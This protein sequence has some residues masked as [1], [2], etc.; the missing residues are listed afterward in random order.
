MSEKNNE[1]LKLW[2]R[3]GVS[4]NMTPDEVSILCGDDYRK[5]TE[6]LVSV[7]HSDRCMLDG[8]TYFPEIVNI[9]EESKVPDVPW[10][11]DLYKPLHQQPDKEKEQLSVHSLN[12]PMEIK[13]VGELRAALANVPDSALLN[14]GTKKL[15]FDVTRIGYDGIS[16]ALESSDLEQEIANPLVPMPGLDKLD[17]TGF[18]VDTPHGTLHVYDKKDNEYPGVWVDLVQEDGRDVTLAMVE[19]ISGGEGLSDFDPRHPEVMRRQREEVPECRRSGDE[20]TAGFVTRSWPDDNHDEEGH[21]RTFHYGYPIPR[22]QTLEE[23]VT[24]AQ[25][26]TARPEPQKPDQ[27]QGRGM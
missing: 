11:F 3:V 21:N 15:G 8:E 13:T 14:I 26:R 9:E 25:E 20:V 17:E 2:A 1:M 27:E 19:Y 5:A 6:M 10:E 22:Q 16:V 12:I 23:K 24:D 18:T 7:L 4:L